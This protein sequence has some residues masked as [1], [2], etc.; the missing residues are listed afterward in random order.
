MKNFSMPKYVSPTLEADEMLRLKQSLG[1]T[2]SKEMVDNIISKL[3]LGVNSTP[4]ERAKWVE[5]LSVLLENTF[6]EDTVKAIRQNCYCNENG[7]LEATAK[8]MKQLYLSHNRDLNRFVNALNENGASWYIQDNQLYTKMFTC[9]CPMLE[10]AKT[11]S[12]LT[13]CHC[14]AGYNKKLFETV[15]EVPI[16]V[17][18]MHSIRQGFEYCLLRITFK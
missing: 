3:P 11:S 16:E 15:F 2:V 6:D 17:E 12:S 18:V 7:R 10:E 9:E 14:T 8:M 5:N 1:M 13:W 4:I